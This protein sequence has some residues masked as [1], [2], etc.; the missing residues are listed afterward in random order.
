MKKG[1]FLKVIGIGAVS[2]LLLNM[3]LFALGKINGL[4]FWAVIIIGAVFAFKV[5]PKMKSN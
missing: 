5:L 2:I 1:N 4:L 3:L